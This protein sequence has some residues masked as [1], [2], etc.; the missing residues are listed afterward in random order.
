MLPFIYIGNWEI[1]THFLFTLS[2]ILIGFLLLIYNIK[3]LDKNT[4]NSLL[5][6][7]ILIFIPFFIGGWLGYELEIL[8][9]NNKLSFGKIKLFESFSLIWGLLFST[10]FAFP[11]AKL[12]KLNVWMAGDFFS[13]SIA[14]G[15]I[16]VKLGCFLNGC[17]FG[18]P[19]SDNFPFAIYY[20]FGSYQYSLFGDSKF[21]PSQLFESA[22]WLIIFLILLIKKNN[23]LFNGELI[24]LTFFFFSLF[25]F[26]VQFTRYY[27]SKLLM[28]FEY[29][30]LLLILVISIIIYI[31]KCK[32]YKSYK[33]LDK[34]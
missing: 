23:K 11:A 5:L 13:M 8:L 16:F 4:K 14:V 20:P 27:D 7:A 25:R 29:F 24:V 12:L 26:L 28:L 9:N 21:Y 2:G 31:I 30:F 32:Y 19:C 3:T 18:L 6:L 22:S 15:G 34:T 33:K 1:S 17:C 10:V